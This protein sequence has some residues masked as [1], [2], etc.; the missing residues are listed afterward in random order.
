MTS[1][2]IPS[3][4]T[5]EYLEGNFVSDYVASFD[6]LD[7][8]VVKRYGERALEVDE[9]TTLDEAVVD[10]QLDVNSIVF[11]H[12]NDWAKMY[13]ALIKDY[14]PLW[15]VDGT[16]VYTYGATQDTDQFGATQKT[17]QYGATQDTLQYGATQKTNQYGATQD[18]MQYGNT[19]VTS[20]YGQTTATMGG[21]TDTHN[22]YERSYPD[23]TNIKTQYDEDIIASRTNTTGQHSDTVTGTTHTDT[24]SSLTHTDTESE[25]TH[26]DTKSSLQ[27]TDTENALQHTDVHSALEHIDSERK[28]GN[29]GVTM[30]QDMLMKEQTLRTMYNFYDVIFKFI[31]KEMGVIYYDWY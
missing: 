9:D 15:N 24:A 26:S 6:M 31:I 20:Q 5:G 21:G 10:W 13:S 23:G 11:A 18:T 19:S 22:H 29:Q 16:T 7:R 14:E 3:Y 27:H 30:T 8:Y 17:N 4:P 2:L 12:L 25:L 28:T 1:D